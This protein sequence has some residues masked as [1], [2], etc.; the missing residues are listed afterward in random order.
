MM[1]Q[2]N[3]K[4]SLQPFRERPFGDI[5]QSI[6]SFFQDAVK[7]LKAPRFIPIYQYE[8]EQEYIVEAELPGVNKE[9]L[10]LDIYHNYIKISILSEEIIREENDKEQIVKQSSRFERSERVVELPFAVN[11]SEVKAKL[12]D[13]LLKI[14][15]PNKRKK[16]KID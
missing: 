12:Q 11:E 8:T 16:I 13:G 10:T 3:K 2:D 1:N 15:I 7:H 4:N 14:R 9:Q 5:L 6:D